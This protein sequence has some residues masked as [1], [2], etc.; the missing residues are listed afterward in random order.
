MDDWM[1]AGLASAIPNIES[2]TSSKTKIS[3]NQGGLP[4]CKIIHAGEEL[5]PDEAQLSIGLK[6]QV[7]LFRYRDKIHAIDHACPHQTYPLSRG[8][9]YDIEDFGVVLSVGISCPKHGWSFDLF[10]GNS[11]RG[12]YKLGL[13][14][15]DV[16]GGENGEEVW[17]K[18]KE[19][20]R[21]G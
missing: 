20:E 15:V 7:L 3:S 5:S 21:I 4:P 11:D 18:K 9:I 2:G 1:Y 8:T 10:T 13:W 12:K 6:P 17:V 16:R 19:R 14:E